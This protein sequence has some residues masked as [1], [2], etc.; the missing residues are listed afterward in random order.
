MDSDEIKQSLGKKEIL[1]QATKAVVFLHRFNYVHR[2][3]KPSNFLIAKDGDVHLVKLSDFRMSKNLDNVNERNHSTGAERRGWIA[4]YQIK[5]GN[6]DTTLAEDVFILGCFFYYVLTDGHHPFE[7]NDTFI[8]D[9]NFHVYKDSWRG[10]RITA[11]ENQTACADELDG[12]A[13]TLIKDMLKFNLSE[14]PT[15]KAILD[16][17][18]FLSDNYYKL[19]DIPSVKPGL[20]VIYNQEIFHDVK[21]NIYSMLLSF[22]HCFVFRF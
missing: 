16:S 15:S 9:P 20:C 19:Y 21:A 8:R 11:G 14:C 1:R 18:Y 3:L 7:E 5:D 10:E 13:I 22:V 2:N 4:P 17:A 12:Q 6:V